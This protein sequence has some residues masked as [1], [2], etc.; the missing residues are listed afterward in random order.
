M[1][2][3]KSLEEKPEKKPRTD[4]KKARNAYL[5][6]TKKKKTT[7]KERRKA[8]KKQLK[9]IERN[10]GYIENL[11]GVVNVE[12][13]LEKKEREKLEIIN[14]LYRQQKEMYEE[15][16]QTIKNRIVS[17]EQPYIR[18]IVRGKAGASVEFGAKI[19]VSY[20]NSYIFLDYV[21][22]ENFAESKYLIEQVEKYKKMWGYY[23]ESIHVDQIYRTKENRKYCKEKGIRMSGPK[24][25]RPPKNID[26]EDKKQSQLDERIRS[27]I[28]GKFG[29]VKRNY[30]LN[31]IR[32]KLKQTS[33]TVMGMGIFVMNLM[34]LF[35][36]VLRVFFYL[37]LEKQL[38]KVVINQKRLYIMYIKTNSDYTLNLSHIYSVKIV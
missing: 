14:E 31:L 19:S 7:R 22:W 13:V 24:L 10:L 29:E 30:G 23:P 8:I 6:V 26:K 27:R 9:Y 37:F 5:S 38:K 17:I 11:I 1:I 2:L 25:G 18:P 32:T 20:V 34:T 28:E 4:R 36:R 12:K 35:R 21:E 33:E 3:Y 15:N 16:K